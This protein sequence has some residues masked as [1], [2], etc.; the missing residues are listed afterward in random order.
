MLFSVL[1]FLV[2]VDDDDHNDDDEVSRNV[3]HIPT[4][5]GENTRIL[6]CV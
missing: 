3:A 6:C 1:F 4:T 5:T 2:Y